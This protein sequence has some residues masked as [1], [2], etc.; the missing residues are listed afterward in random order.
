MVRKCV[1]DWGSALDSAGG[2]Y[3][4]PPDSLAAIRVKGKGSEGTKE[5]GKNENGKGWRKRGGDP[6]F[7]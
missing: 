6:S 1:G 3:S 7:S 2:A 4:A 5:E